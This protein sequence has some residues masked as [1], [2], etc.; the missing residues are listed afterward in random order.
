MV[1]ELQSNQHHSMGKLTKQAHL[2]AAE[3]HR[4]FGRALAGAWVAVGAVEVTAGEVERARLR[5]LGDAK[6]PTRRAANAL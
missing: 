1:L 3:H 6:H 4:R 5:P 2:P